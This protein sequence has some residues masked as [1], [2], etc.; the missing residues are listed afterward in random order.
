MKKAILTFLLA[1]VTI[2][3]NAQFLFRISGNGLKEPSY[4]LGTLHTLPASVK[5]DSIPEYI[6][7]E[8][9]CRQLYAEVDTGATI[10]VAD[11]LTAGKQNMFLPEGETIGDLL[12]PEQFALLKVKVKELTNKN[13][14]RRNNL[15]PIN[16]LIIFNRAIEAEAMKK[17]CG[18]NE[19]FTRIDMDCIDRAVKRDMTLGHLDQYARIDSM[20]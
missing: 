4:I 5:L 11:A 8:E 3:T 14:S 1:L 17:Y 20:D 6:E 15:K 18:G 19:A 13:L 12:T 7:A 16:F 2:T 10:L 9:K